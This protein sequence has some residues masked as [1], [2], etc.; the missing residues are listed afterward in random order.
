MKNADIVFTFQDECDD[1][2]QPSIFRY[3]IM[4]YHSITH[5]VHICRVSDETGSLET[6][7]V[8][9]GTLDRGYLEPKDGMTCVAAVCHQSLVP[10]L[11]S[12]HHRHRQEA[13]RLGWICSQPR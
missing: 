5:S 7:L 9:E 8:S 6:T 4:L 12:L 2:F 13:V 3:V 1:E 10:A 11:Y